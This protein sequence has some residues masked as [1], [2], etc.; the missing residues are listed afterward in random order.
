MSQYTSGDDVYVLAADER[1]LIQ[2]AR[3]EIDR[4]EI[5]SPADVRAI[6]DKYRV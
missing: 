2:E 4:G 3:D 5:A 6:Y 1:K